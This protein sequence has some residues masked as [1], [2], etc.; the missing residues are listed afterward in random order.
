M[1][2][3]ASTLFSRMF[4]LLVSKAWSCLGAAR[5]ERHTHGRL[6]QAP[7]PCSCRLS[8]GRLWVGFSFSQQSPSLHTGLW[9]FMV[10]HDSASKGS[11]PKAG[12]EVHV[13]PN[14]GEQEVENG[15][16]IPKTSAYQRG[17]LTS[18]TWRVEIHGVTESIFTLERSLDSGSFL[19]GQNNNEAAKLRKGR[20]EQR[21]GTKTGVLMV[22]G[23]N[24]GCFSPCGVS[25]PGSPPWVEL[26]KAQWDSSFFLA[27]F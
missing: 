14:N 8:L 13:C 21:A 20:K 25:E 27:L 5:A 7:F 6:E 16:I 19:Y 23:S 1:K 4:L 15:R 3:C 12:E 2:T 22:R 18:F 17:T 24:A 11:T 9:F 26:S 10:D